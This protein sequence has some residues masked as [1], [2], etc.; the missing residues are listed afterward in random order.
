MYVKKNVK[1][2]YGSTIELM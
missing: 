1:E 2:D